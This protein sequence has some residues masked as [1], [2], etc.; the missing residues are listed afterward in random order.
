MRLVLLAFCLGGAVSIDASDAFAQGAP[1]PGGADDLWTR[2]D[3]FGDLGGLRTVLGNHG[4]T[5]GLQETSEFLGNVAGGI[6]RGFDYDGLTTA[7]LG[8]DSGKTLGWDGGSFNAS[9]LQIHGRNLSAD[10]LD[11][12]QTASGIEANRA[13]RLWELWYQQSFRDDAVDVKLGQQSLDQEFIVS[14]YSGLFL[15]TMTGWPMVPSADLYGGGPAYPLSSLGIRLKA[16]PAGALTL[17]GGAFDDNPPGGPFSN[18]SQ[19]RGAERA[20]VKF[21]L[22]SGVLFIGEV[23]YA[24][25][26]P[27]ADDAH[28]PATASTGLPGTYKLGMW[29]DTAAFPDPR[30]DSNG[31]SLA[32]PASN[33]MPLMRRHNFSIYGVVDQAIWHPAAESPQ[34]LGVFA[35]AMGAP[36]DRNLIAFSVNAGVDLKAPLPARDDDSFGLGFGFAQIGANARGLD[37]DMAAFSP[38]QFSPVRSSETFVELTYQAQIAPWWQVQPDLQYV[39][40][41]GAGIQNPKAPGTRIGDELVLGVRTNITF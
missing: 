35:R 27:I 39:V 16:K 29:Y 3:L 22:G 7:T 1:S 15:N 18:D 17:L 37:R 33:G 40:N 31:R 13:T 10:Y 5:V 32:D 12:L 34:A 28:R 14:Q 21:N 19:L 23:Q 38:G 36:G 11:N 9:M 6:G 20:G 24:I 26:Q 4:I 8:I 2:A 25:N 30:F 41:P